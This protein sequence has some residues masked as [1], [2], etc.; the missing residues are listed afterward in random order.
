VQDCSKVNGKV[1]V[2]RRLFTNGSFFA[3]IEQATCK[4][5]CLSASQ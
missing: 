5:R 1:S 4:T 3:V 2:N